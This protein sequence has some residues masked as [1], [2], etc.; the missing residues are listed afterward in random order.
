MANEV[1]GYWDNITELGRATNSMLIPGVVEENPFRNPFLDKAPIAQAGG[2]GPS[3]KWLR[4]GSRSLETVQ[5]F[6]LGEE[7][8]WSK[9]SNYTPVETSLKMC[10]KAIRLDNFVKDIYQTVNNYREMAMGECETDC[11]LKINQKFVYDDTNFN[12]K[13]FLGLHGW[14]NLQEGAT[15]RFSN[16]AIDAGEKGL[17]LW[18]LRQLKRSMPYGID[19]WWMPGVILDLISAAY[20]EKGF[21]GL[22]SATAG[23]Y[24]QITRTID[25]GTGQT[26]TKYADVQII[27]TDYLVA[28]Q[29]NTGTSSTDPR[30][31]YATGTENYS[32]FGIKW[33][34]IMGGSKG[35]VPGMCYAFGN[36]RGAGD[37]FKLD[38]FDKLPNF[39]GEGI[40]LINYGA[41]LLG[42]KLCLGRIRDIHADDAVTA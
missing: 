28:E 41:P 23:A 34:S 1:I 15:G 32:I 11:T 2:T 20:E 27:D 22:A 31:L 39:D 14:A 42:S 12:S 5:D 9:G 33:G 40:R 30:L 38:V 8:Q 3:I 21:A 37:F 35:K 25:Q 36:T 19:Q 16:L 7:L 24:A 4:S 29:A 17:S 10:Y 26:I 6:T 18:N 13:M